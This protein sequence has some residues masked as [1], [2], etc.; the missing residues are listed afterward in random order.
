MSREFDAL[1]GQ[2]LDSFPNEKETVIPKVNNT[3]RLSAILK[4]RAEGYFKRAEAL[5]AEGD[6]ASSVAAMSTC[7]EL[8]YVAKMLE[9]GRIAELEAHRRS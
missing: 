5:E 4:S 7:K 1:Y 9:D 6:V 8:A 3:T 2:I